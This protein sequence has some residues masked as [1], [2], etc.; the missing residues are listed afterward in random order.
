MP[1]GYIIG[2]VTVKDATAYQAYIAGNTPII[3]SYGGRPIVRGGACDT[4]EGPAFQRHIVFEFP[5]YASAK[6]LYDDPAYQKVAQIR[7]DTADSMI[8][9]VEGV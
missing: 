6:A 7:R 8:V 3:A 2:H 9:V 5:D 4:P 1:K